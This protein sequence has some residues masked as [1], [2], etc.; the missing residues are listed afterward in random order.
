MDAT[1]KIFVGENPVRDPLEHLRPGRLALYIQHVFD[2]AFT[3]HYV[4]RIAFRFIG[5]NFFEGIHQIFAR[6]VDDVKAIAQTLDL[7]QRL[8]LMPQDS[9]SALDR[10]EFRSQ[11]E[12]MSEPSV[13]SV[14]AQAL[15]QKMNEQ[16]DLISHA[17]QAAEAASRAASAAGID[18]EQLNRRVNQLLSNISEVEIPSDLGFR[19]AG[20]AGGATGEG[21]EGGLQSMPL[22]SVDLADLKP[23][24]KIETLET[25]D[26]VDL[27]GRIQKERGGVGSGTGGS[28][29][30]AGAVGD[31]GSEEIQ[32]G[33]EPGTAMAVRSQ[34]PVRSALKT[35]LS[36]M[37]GENIMT[38]I[39]RV[40]ENIINLVSHLFESITENPELHG[41]V[42]AQISRA[43]LPVM[44]LALSDTALFQSN[45]HPARTFI[46]KL[47]DLGLKVS[48]TEEE[49]YQKIKNSVNNLLDRFEGNSD[50]F[51]ELTEEIEEYI[52]T[53][54]YHEEEVTEQALLDQVAEGPCE[55]STFL[56]RQQK[57]T[58]REFMFHRF[59]KLVWEALLSRIH[60]EN[61]DQSYQWKVASN[62]YA[63]MIWSTQV[64]AKSP[65]VQQQVLRRIPK[66]VSTVRKLFSDYELSDGVREVILNYMFRIHM[67]IVKGTPLME[68]ED[69]FGRVL[70]AKQQVKAQEPV[71]IINVPTLIE[72]AAASAE[73]DTSPS[74][75]EID[76]ADPSLAYQYARENTGA[77]DFGD[78][79]EASPP[80]VEVEM[81][82]GVPEGGASEESVQAVGTAGT[83]GDAKEQTDDIAHEI[84]AH[85]SVPH[86]NVSSDPD[87]IGQPPKAK[88]AAPIPEELD[89]SA[90]LFTGQEELASAFDEAKTYKVGEL[91]ELLRDGLKHRYQLT[92]VSNIFGKYTF[93]E[94][95]TR[96]LL[97]VGKPDLVVDIL[98]GSI[99]RISNTAIFDNSLESVISQI[100]GEGDDDDDENDG[101]EEG[102]SSLDSL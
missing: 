50:I 6:W 73:A 99:Q 91:F 40:S 12:A 16:S 22:S 63:E 59:S 97:E 95:G 32:V 69:D 35:A 62:T 52:N 98:R 55:V 38:V 56:T 93:R 92:H 89:I 90:G 44:R 75:T 34:D 72:G 87:L 8:E 77:I 23:D 100:R 20:G 76:R 65:H 58:K 19:N 1:G 3:N 102:I 83:A 85:D 5:W 13:P 24:T 53:A 27:L 49:G 101:E 82:E 28:G 66:I 48:S 33:S 96:T 51:E 47:G 84:I 14:V 94:F 54:G 31:F 42:G 11:N 80:V 4:A 67:Q 60:D 64:D 15:S 37:S 30:G 70:G 71:D 26:L 81:A 57:N 21:L 61:G 25:N 79:D 18:I 36:N 7:R 17:T 45:D 86:D 41:E 68:I 2:R 39:D 78:A 43:Q 88:A 10:R 46:N 29:G 9:S 74:V